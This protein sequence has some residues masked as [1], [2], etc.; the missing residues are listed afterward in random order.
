MPRGCRC[1]VRMGKEEPSLVSRAESDRNGTSCARATGQG[2]A[3]PVR[4]C[5]SSWSAGRRKEQY[6]EVEGVRPQ[7]V[8][9]AGRRKGFV[10][11]NAAKGQTDAK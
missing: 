3:F 11:G 4:G 9:A 8:S 6:G 1:H 10:G 5:Q 7:C 2:R